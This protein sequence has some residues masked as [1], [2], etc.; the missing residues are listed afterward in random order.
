MRQRIN[1]VNNDNKSYMLEF[2]EYKTDLAGARPPYS[3]VT[4]LHGRKVKSDELDVACSKLY[5]PPN[6][7]ITNGTRVFKTNQNSKCKLNDI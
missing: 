4:K 3:R 1:D 6:S 2:I 7:R 5:K